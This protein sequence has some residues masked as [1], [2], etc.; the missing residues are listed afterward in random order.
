M[1]LAQI[2]DFVDSLWARSRSGTGIAQYRTARMHPEVNL[3]IAKRKVQERF[4]FLKGL[5]PVGRWVAP[6]DPNEKT[7]LLVAPVFNLSLSKPLLRLSRRLGTARTSHTTRRG[8][9]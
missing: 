6:I 8:R 3:I 5:C 7:V 1:S 4:L 9:G 2:H